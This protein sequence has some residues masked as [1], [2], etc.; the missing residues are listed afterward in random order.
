MGAIATGEA[1]FKK[2]QRSLRSF[3]RPLQ[4]GQELRETSGLM[5]RSREVDSGVYSHRRGLSLS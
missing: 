2:A 4:D 5:Y 1:A 3:E